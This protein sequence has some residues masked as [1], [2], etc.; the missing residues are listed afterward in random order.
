[1]LAGEPALGLVLEAGSSLVA[2]ALARTGFEFLLV[3][4]QHGDWDD[5]RSLGAFQGISLGTAVPMA[6]VRGNDFY[7]IGR[8]LD[9]GALGIVVPMVNSAA[10]AQAAAF[11]MRYPP[12]GGR[13]IGATLA[14]FHGPDYAGWIDEEVFL[15]VQIET[16]QGLACAEEILAVDGVDGCWVGPSDLGRSLGIDLRTPE[17]AAAHEKAILTVRDACRRAGKIPGLYCFDLPDAQ[18]WLR[19]GFQFVTIGTDTDLLVQGSAGILR[20]LGH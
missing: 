4:N 12:R 14:G 3:D 7:A 15:A 1:M 19:H 5:Q 8:L 13:S 10:E 17:G 6:R 16:A 20:E 2:T 11:A 18:R 9:R